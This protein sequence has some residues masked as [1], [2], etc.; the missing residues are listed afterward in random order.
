MGGHIRN[1]RRAPLPVF[2]LV[3][4]AGPHSS[5]NCSCLHHA[6][7]VTTDAEPYLALGAVKKA[8]RIDKLECN[9]SW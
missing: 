1:R 4:P 8:N 6:R 2:E 3:I 7:Q 9:P 5:A